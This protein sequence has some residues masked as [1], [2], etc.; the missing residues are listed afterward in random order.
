MESRLG[1]GPGVGHPHCARMVQ[2]VKQVSV[3]TLAAKSHI[4]DEVI[5]NAAAPAQGSLPP[6]ALP[7]SSVAH[8]LCGKQ[9]ATLRGAL[10]RGPSA[11][12]RKLGAH[13]QGGSEGPACSHVG[14]LGRCSPVTPS[15]ETVTQPTA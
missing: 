11:E 14:D 15:D 6:P 3:A 8:L 10:S 13:R 2:S 7:L 12:G 4:Q 1:R 9:A 5:K